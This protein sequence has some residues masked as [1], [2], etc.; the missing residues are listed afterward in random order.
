MKARETNTATSV[1]CYKTSLQIQCVQST[2][3]WQAKLTFAMS[4]A[5]TLGS[6]ETRSR[7]KTLF[8]T[9]LAMSASPRM[10]QKRENI[11][12]EQAKNV[13]SVRVISNN[14]IK[15]ILTTTKIS[16]NKR[17]ALFFQPL[18]N[19]INWLFRPVWH[20]RFVSCMILS[21]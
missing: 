13:Y 2:W 12:S 11:S 9:L 16:N 7:E 14:K 5:I 15:N 10:H 6:L 4:Q 3:A 21:K 20:L 17:R 8:F 18:N 1:H 19:Y